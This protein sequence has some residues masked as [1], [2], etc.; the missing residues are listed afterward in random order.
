M[1]TGFIGLGAMGGPM[2]ANLHK[3][4]QLHT[5]WNRTRE[6]AAWAAQ[7]GIELAPDP[8][9][10]ASECELI[11]TSVS[12]DAALVEVIDRLRPKLGTGKVVVDTSTISADTARVAARNLAEVDS[13]FLDAP[14]SGGVEGARKGTLAMMIG[15]DTTVLERVQ[16]VLSVL[17]SRITHIGPVGSGQAAKAVN[18]I[19]VAGINQSVSESLAFAQALGLPMETLIDVLSTGAASNWFLSNRGQNMVKQEYPP[20]FRVALHYKDLRI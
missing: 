1:K 11:L 7:A 8:E 12:D 5:A 13:A 10:L 6:R 4:G 15:G 20:G 14:V 19:M 3:A 2:A 9:A 17:A 16:P 18:Q